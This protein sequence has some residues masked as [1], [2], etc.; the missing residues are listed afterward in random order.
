MKPILVKEEP[1]CSPNKRPHID[2][3]EPDEVKPGDKMIVTGRFFGEK[4][5]CLY[6]VIIGSEEAKNLTYIN[7]QKVE[8][9]VPD[10]ARPGMTF[11]NIQSGGGAA[12]SAILVQRAQ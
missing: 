6:K 1:I 11:L 8:V 5:E 2:A 10:S 3:V 12:R 7:E 4:K 9:I